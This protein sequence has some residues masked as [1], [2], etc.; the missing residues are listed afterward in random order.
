LGH[1]KTSLDPDIWEAAKDF[2]T[3]AM[4]YV[5]EHCEADTLVLRDVFWR[6][7]RVIK[8]VHR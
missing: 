7:R 8:V 1:S 3:W 5:C 4:D 2:E 6:Y